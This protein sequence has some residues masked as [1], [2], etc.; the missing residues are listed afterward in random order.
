MS[1]IPPEIW[2]RIAFYACTDG[3]AMGAVLQLVSR[4]VADGTAPHKNDIVMLCS[5]R[6]TVS[7]HHYLS[8]PDLNPIFRR[9]KDL[10]IGAATTRQGELV[11]ETWD[12]GTTIYLSNMLQLVSPY[13]RSLTL[14]MR[15]YTVSG[16]S[17]LRFPCLESLTLDFVIPITSAPKLTA[18]H[19]PLYR[20]HPYDAPHAEFVHALYSQAPALKR[21]TVVGDESLGN[22]AVLQK[23]NTCGSDHDCD[24]HDRTRLSSKP[25]QGEFIPNPSITKYVEPSPEPENFNIVSGDPRWN[26]PQFKQGI[27]TVLGLLQRKVLV[28]KEKF[29]F[30]FVQIL[31]SIAARSGSPSQLLAQEWSDMFHRAVLRG[32]GTAEIYAE[33]YQLESREDHLKP[34]SL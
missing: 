31:G 2:A 4:L 11:R 26:D 27:L 10:Y 7:I 33:D 15:D 34:N 8:S 12:L 19:L 5:A 9:V 23:L 13:L 6:Q 29:Q 21:I 1:S 24:K 14:V 20:H 28:K 18:L 32:T 17:S 22:M 30:R 25:Q 16:L 3:G